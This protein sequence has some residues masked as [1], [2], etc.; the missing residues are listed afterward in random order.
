MR[1]GGLAVHRTGGT[2]KKIQTF[3]GQDSINMTPDVY[4]HLFED[5]DQDASIF[6][7]LEHNLVAR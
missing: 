5:A 6:E 2:P 3:L 4:G 7:E 1:C